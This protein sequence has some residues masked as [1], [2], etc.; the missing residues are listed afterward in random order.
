MNL[1]KLSS[2]RSKIVL[3]IVVSIFLLSF[4]IYLVSNRLLLKSYEEIEKSQVTQDLQ[5][6]EDSIENI[7]DQLGIKLIDWAWWDDTYQFI[8]DK[9]EDYITSNLGNASLAN[10]K[11]N[12]MVFMDVNHN[13]VYKKLVNIESKK[14]LPFESISEHLKVKDKNFL[15]MT[16]GSFTKGILLLP[17]GPMIISS[18]SILNS[19]GTGEPKGIILFGRFIDDELKEEIKA[20][21]HLNLNIY[22][23]Q[24][25]SLPNDVSEAKK[26]ISETDSSFV[27]PLSNSIILGFSVLNDVYGNP[28]IVLK[29]ESTREVYD[30]GKKTLISFMVLAILTVIV[31]G[32]L[33]IVLFE[34]FFIYRFSFLSREVRD[35]GETKNFKSRVTEGKRDEIG[36]FARTINQMLSALSG[37]ID[38]EEKFNKEILTSEQKLNDR[39]QEIEKINKLMIDRELKMIELKKELSQFKNKDE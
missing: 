39:L 28:A 33:I 26:K 32:I 37:A 24:D 18:S 2:I 30:Q 7:I 17:E 4:F 9:N 12:A 14:E 1:K 10:L 25:L 27:K 22:N 38:K 35:I 8:E 36:E 11:I 20:L 19:E 15:S 29:T 23:F 31:F 5:R 13:V 21:T 3:S 34:I 6:A 16:P